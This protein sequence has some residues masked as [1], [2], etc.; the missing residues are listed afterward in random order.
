MDQCHYHPSNNIWVTIDKH[1]KEL[2]AY[3]YTLLWS[4]SEKTWCTKLYTKWEPGQLAGQELGPCCLFLLPPLLRTGSPGHIPRLMR[5][6]D[7]LLRRKEW[8]IAWGVEGKASLEGASRSHS[9]FVPLDLG[10]WSP[11]VA[12]CCTRGVHPCGSPGPLDNHRGIA[13]FESWGNNAR[14][15][16]THMVK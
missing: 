16:V 10:D 8:L 9:S 2:E 3:L 7:T 5:Y 11:A 12:P 4:A 14:S 15:V 13:I 6:A 1:K